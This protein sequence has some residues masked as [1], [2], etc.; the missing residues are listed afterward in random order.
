MKL[1]EYETKYAALYAEFARIVQFI[2]EKA[3]ELEAAAV[4]RPQSIQYRAKAAK[5]LK[6]KLEAR[7]LVDSDTI[8][9]LIKDLAGVRLIFYTNTDVDRFLNARIIPENF[10]VDWNETRIHHPTLENNQQRYQAI[11]YTVR[12][13][14]ERIALPEYAKFNDLRCEVQIQTIL[15]RAWAETSHDILYKPDERKGFGD[16]A[17]QSIESR[18]KRIMD[19]YLLPAGYEFQKVQHDFERLRQGKELF[20]RGV[21][22]A[23]ESSKGNNERH[24]TLLRLKEHV[25]PNYDDIR[26][27]YAELTRALLKS[28]SDARTS[29][30]EL[31]KTPFGDF[32][33]KTSQEVVNLVI[34]IFDYL[35]YVDVAVTF[36]ALCTIY[37]N[38]G[39]R[40]ARKQI[41]TTIEHLAGFDI[42]VWKKAGPHVQMALIDIVEQLDASDRETLAP[43]VS[44]ICQKCL[45]AGITGTS[46][47]VDSI[48]FRSGALPATGDVRSIRDKALSILFER[49]E[50][51]SSESQKREI[52][53][54]L[55]EATRLPTQ[56]QYSNELCTFVLNDTKRII[57]QLTGFI[58]SMSFELLEHVEHAVMYEYRRARQI[59]NADEDR[60]GCKELAGALNREILIFC[61]KVNWNQTFVRYKTLVGFESVFPQHWE[62][63]DFEIERVDAYRQKCVEEYIEG[64]TAESKDEW[65]QLI[66][67]CTA[68]KS[69]DMATFPTFGNFIYRLSKAKPDIADYFLIRANEDVVNFLPAFLNGLFESG[70]TDTYQ[71]T[72]DRFFKADTHMV[73][74]ARHWRTSKPPNPTFI[75]GV[76]VK[77]IASDDSIAVSECLVLAIENYG[78]LAQPPVDEFFVP[79]IQYLTGRNDARWVRGAWFLREAKAFFAELSAAHAELVL[80]NMKGVSRIEH[81]VERILSLIAEK[82]P[83][84]VWEFLT[85]R[86]ADKRNKEHEERFEAIPYQFH[87][88]EKPLS[89]DV[90]LAVNAVRNKYTPDDPLF[91]FDGGRL[92]YAVFPQ[93]APIFALKLIALVQNGE[94][95]DIS[96]VLGILQNYEGAPEIQDILKQVVIRVTDTDPRLEQ[97]EICLESTGVV[98]GEFGMV[99]A[100]RKKKGETAA[101]LENE[102]HPKVRAFAEQYLPKLDRRI[103]VEQRRADQSKELRKRIFEYDDEELKD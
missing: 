6:A 44:T 91:R 12:L 49:F 46:H 89:V 13:K 72:L 4:P 18:L 38:E 62:D 76:L 98:R 35:R 70:A 63:E 73:S 83:A 95:A 47:A 60:F 66:E 94:D 41:I 57:E 51:A 59:A 37:R 102:E 45:E 90:G 8:E 80:N 78:G 19:E 52:F 36:H 84:A 93:F 30:V 99:E 58:G 21:I 96:F 100:I 20:D 9:K 54:T 10:D 67:L 48:T 28:A 61:D 32:P 97:V 85:G 1:T 43:I 65:Y 40:D 88:L 17:R 68:T 69:N 16:K 103:A 86:L 11:H 82:Y 7:G 75:K 3:L 14:P 42:N 53:S 25:I 23:L 101:W 79:A 15:I 77:A 5:S 55:W 26:G 33:G 24:E 64:I 56:A 81:Q 50:K 39:D 34:D 71:K 27:I 22:E 74:I 2:V 87:G 31:I 92:L 29:T